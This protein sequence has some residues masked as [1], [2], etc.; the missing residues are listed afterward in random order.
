MFIKRD[1]RKIPQILADTEDERSRMLLSKRSHEFEGNLDLLCRESNVKQLKNLRVLNLYENQLRSIDGI[2]ILGKTPLED[3]NLGGNQLTTLPP[4]MGDLSNLKTLW[5]DDN[6]LAD[7]PIV[8]CSIKSLEELRMSGN[9]LHF[10]PQ[11]INALSNLKTLALDNNKIEDFPMGIL[12]LPHLEN[13][14][15]RQNLLRE[16]PDSLSE[17]TVLQTLSVSSNQLSSLPSSLYKIHTLKNIF[18]NAN[19]MTWVDKELSDLPALEKLN[20]ANNKL[21]SVPVAWHD[22]WGK[23]DEEKGKLTLEE[24]EQCA[25]VVTLKGNRL[26]TEV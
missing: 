22:K 21:T 15:L 13:L 26:R 11:S 3:L 7:F 8:L 17:L 5:L 19:G 14:W 10:I 23:Y 2:G 6:H 9:Q 25:V 20:L 12:E 1:A 16:L 18:A 24:G 4:D